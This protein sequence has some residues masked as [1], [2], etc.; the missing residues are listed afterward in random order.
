MDMNAEKETRVEPPGRAGLRV[1]ILAGMALVAL[2]PLVVMAWQGY[3]CARCSIVEQQ[4]KH[5]RTVLESRKDCLV[6]WLDERRSDLRFLAA[7]PYARRGCE[8]ECGRATGG[9][10][11]CTDLLENFREG[12][13]AYEIIES[14]NLD[15]EPLQRSCSKHCTREKVLNE[16]FASL[17]AG[18][19]GLVVNTP[20]PDWDGMICLDMGHPLL[21]DS[22]EKVGY[23]VAGLNLSRAMEP[24]L[25][26]R[27][28]LGETGKVY[29]VSKEGVIQSE[30]LAG[31]RLIGKPAGLPGGMP[32]DSSEAV[33]EYS[34]HRGVDVLGAATTFPDTPF[35]IVTEI[36]QAEAFGQLA[37]LKNRAVVT[38][39]IT[40]AAVLLIALRTAGRISHP[41]K[42]LAAVARR[43]SQGRREERLGP[44]S[45]TEARE[46]AAAFNRM[47][48]ELD[49]AQ[50]RLSHAAALAAIGE[51]STSVVHEIR[52]PLSSIKMNINTLRKEVKWDSAHSELAEIASRQVGRVERMLNDLLQYGKPLDINPEPVLFE[53][54]VRDVL[55]VTGEKAREKNV[56]IKI[57]DLLKEDKIAVDGEQI[58][59][60]LANLVTNAIQAVD[61]GGSIIVA[62][63]PEEKDM[64]RIAV[65]DSGPGIP[66]AVLEK[67]FQPFVTTRE[68]GTGLGLANVKKIVEY[69][70]GTVSAV[71]GADNG[72]DNG[73]RGAIFSILI[74]KRS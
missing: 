48:D 31:D 46:V 17:L 13:H 1:R 22:G 23:L 68:D 58:T 14:Y 57:T 65:T 20:A 36:D 15:W 27:S 26:N 3:R 37:V 25:Q 74:P 67:L 6:N 45:G 34:D 9:V 4:E 72:A 18:A 60:A 53:E 49:A 43:I 73:T 52:N 19:D 62:G 28:G 63:M 39:L 44:M 70:G 10:D 21:D 8:T 12:S 55:E 61:E 47:L 2:C 71:N 29:I 7:T 33:F 11:G 42:E 69:H 54:L 30:P 5:L 38:G 59:R 35:S 24:I 56:H 51:L 50:R 64:I 32:A 40:L 16:G 41:L 66:G